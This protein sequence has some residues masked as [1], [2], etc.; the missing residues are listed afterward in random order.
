VQAISSGDPSTATN[1]GST[2]DGASESYLGRVNFSLIDKYL[3]TVNVRDDGSSNFPSDIRWALT[4]SGA[5]AWK[6]KNEKFLEKA[7]AINDLKLRLS[8]GLTNNQGIPGN[9]YVTQLTTVA[10][11]LSGTAQFQSNL[12][13]PYVQWEKTKSSNIGLDGALFNWK[14]DFSV[15]VYDRITDGLLLKE[16]FPQYTGTTTSYSP[17]AMAAPYVNVGSISNK[18]FDIRIGTTNIDTKIFKWKTDLTVSHNEN[19]VL[20]L[21]SGGTDA[22]LT[23]GASRTVVGQPIGEFYGYVY[24]G[25]FATANDFK[26]HALPADQSGNPLPISKSYGGIWYGDHMYKD[27]NGDGIIDTRDQTNLGSPYPAFTFGFNNTFT[28]KNFDLNIFFTG[29]YGNKVYNELAQAQDNPLTNTNYFTG[30]LNYARTALI[31]PTGDATNVNNVYVTNPNTTILSLRNDDTNQNNRFS[32]LY[33]ED[34]SFIRCKTIAL[35]Y[36][37][38]KSVLQKVHMNS[39]RIY[40]N[41]MNAFIITKYTGMDPEIG[42]WN[43]LQS[44]Y[45]SGYYPQS[46]VYTIGLNVKL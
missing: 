6:I 13:N 3:F 46:R 31:N 45:D 9:T 8:Y 12:A 4:S 18:G 19:K 5:F 20:S 21:G 43:P 41:I 7:T 28:Y 10:N 39:L 16:P 35:G 11:G 29:S 44:G 30:V 32:S 1:G 15:D 40:V 22:N 17:G 23:E 26:T 42:S 37:F 33:L 38:P 24:D 25:I 36:N 2:G 14:I 27:L 34:G